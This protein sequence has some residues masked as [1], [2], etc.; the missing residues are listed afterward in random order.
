MTE[1][2]H[3]IAQGKSFPSR[4][5]LALQEKGHTVFCSGCIADME[6]DLSRV[7]VLL[8]PLSQLIDEGQKVNMVVGDAVSE[9]EEFALAEMEHLPVVSVFDLLASIIDEKAKVVECNSQNSGRIL[10]LIL[11]ALHKQS[12]KADYVVDDCVGPF[13]RAVALSENTRICLLDGDLLLRIGQRNHKSNILILSSL[14]WKESV[15]YPTFEDYL[16]ARHRLIS[17]IDREGTL[18]YNQTVAVFQEWA[19]T[20][21]EDITALPFKAHPCR[22]DGDRVFLQ[23]TKNEIELPFPCDE[24]LLRDISAARLACRQFGITDKAF[25]EAV[26]SAHFLATQL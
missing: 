9:N 3:I 1:N 16:E 21:R 25:Y 11:Y 23:Y 20:L 4:L 14:R 17:T 13:S 24:N 18:I 12:K 10:S 5:A 22:R 2:I 26:V 15:E 7:G 8:A 6:S 19:E